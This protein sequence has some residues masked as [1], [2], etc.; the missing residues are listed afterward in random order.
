MRG[1]RPM[2]PNLSLHPTGGI[3]P[4]DDGEVVW[5][6]PKDGESV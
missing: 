4:L 6:C 1:V 3:L 5:H 2:R